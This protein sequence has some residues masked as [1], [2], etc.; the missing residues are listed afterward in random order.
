MSR[1]AKFPLPLLSTAEQLYVTAISAGWGKEDDCVLVRLYLPDRPNLVAQLA[2]QLNSPKVPTSS[3]SDIADLLVGVHLAAMAEAMS[4]CEYLGI[5]TNM[6]FDVVSNAAGASSIFLK[7]FP[8]M[9]GAGWSLRAV[10]GIERI[11]ER[12]VSYLYIRLYYLL[13]LE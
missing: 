9:Q 10:D 13:T 4:Y 5:D 8:E 11:R 1:A 2:Q 7:A 3:V 6:M 12:L